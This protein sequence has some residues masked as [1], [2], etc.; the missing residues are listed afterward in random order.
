MSESG[1]IDSIFRGDPSHFQELGGGA[2][3]FT[4]TE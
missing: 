4:T 1:G 3:F 2:L